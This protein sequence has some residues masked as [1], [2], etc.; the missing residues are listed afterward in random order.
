MV[1]LRQCHGRHCAPIHLRQA[2][3]T[4]PSTRLM[5]LGL[6]LIY[7]KMNLTCGSRESNLTL[8]YSRAVER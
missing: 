2:P 3:R 5:L 8:R 6:D 4:P 7:I 1:N